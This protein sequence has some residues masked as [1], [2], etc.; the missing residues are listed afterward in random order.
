M[1]IYSA[2]IAKNSQKTFWLI[3]FVISAFSQMTVAQTSQDKIEVTPFK[4]VKIFTAEKNELKGNF[5]GIEAAYH[6]NMAKNNSPY[7][8]MLNIRDIDIVATYRNMEDVILNNDPDSKGLLGSA[9]GI[10]GRLEIGLLK[11]GP[12]RLLFTPGLGFVYSTESYFTNGNPITG[13]H[14]NLSAQV[15]LKVSTAI[16][17]TTAIQTGMDVY[18]YSNGAF[19]LPNNG[20]NAYNFTLGVVQNINYERAASTPNPAYE[21]FHRHSVDLGVDVGARGVFKQDKHF[22]R[23][24]L[25]ANYSYRLNRAFSLKLG[26]DAVYYDQ[27]L[28]P[29]RFDETFQ[30]YGASYDKWRVGLSAGTDI[31][32]GRLVIMANFGRYLHYN[33]YYPTKYYWTAGM[34]YYVLPWLALQGKGYVHNTEADYI[35]IGL[36]VKI[37]H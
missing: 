8:K 19:R 4:G 31:W 25:Y 34:K 17:P 27:V 22:Y 15:G 20:V 32:L 11:A 1:S 23:T 33:S 2:T 10:G 16:T 28:D 24:G 21:N 35:G 37:N 26:T 29:A 12:V 14:L 9:F 3:A 36:A 30:Y 7:I 18:H 13:S 5:Y 6:F